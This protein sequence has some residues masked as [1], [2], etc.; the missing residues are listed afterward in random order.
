MNK[1]LAIILFSLF[2]SLQS[3]N[4]QDLTYSN[5]KMSMGS[6]SYSS[7]DDLFE[8][9]IEAVNTSGRNWDGDWNLLNFDGVS[10]WNYYFCDPINCIAVPAVTT[11]SFSLDSAESVDFK[12]QFEPNGVSSSDT[13]VFE[14]AK[15]GGSQRD[16]LTYV[17]NIDGTISSIGSLDDMD[18]YVSFNGYN[19]I[20]RISNLYSFNG[21][22][23]LYNII[24]KK[25]TEHLVVDQPS[26]DLSMVNFPRGVYILKLVDE[27]GNQFSSTFRK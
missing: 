1:F 27:K 8:L 14:I 19:Q 12:A 13:I 9:E 7:T 18:S 21:K 22:I 6:F 24:G 17:V 23:E 2:I 25:L 15:S 5:G 16:T 4:S 10:T 26:F 11:A 3:V 20:A